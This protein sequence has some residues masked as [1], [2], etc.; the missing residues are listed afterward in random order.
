MADNSSYKLH[1]G[2]ENTSKTINYGNFEVQFPKNYTNNSAFIGQH[3]LTMPESIVNDGGLA[4]SDWNKNN[5]GKLMSCFE[6][7][8][9]N[10]IEGWRSDTD[11]NTSEKAQEADWNDDDYTFPDRINT[12]ADLLRYIFMLRWKLEN[13]QTA[14]AD[15]KLS[16]SPS[17]LTVQYHSTS[18]QFITATATQSNTK[19]KVK[20]YEWSLSN[21]KFSISA[22]KDTEKV[23]IRHN[24][25]D[26]LTSTWTLQTPTTSIQQQ[27]TSTTGIAKVRCNPRTP[28]E[29]A[30][31]PSSATLTCKVKWTDNHEESKSINV[32]S[33]GYTSGTKP[34]VS[35]YQWTITSGSL[36]ADLSND[37]S[38]ECTL[39]GKSAG[40]VKVKCTVT[41]S[42]RSTTE[43]NEV[44]ITV[45][46]PKT[47]YYWYAGQTA[48]TTISGTPTVDDTNFTNNK[49]HTIGTTLTNISKLVTGGI[50]GEEWYVAVPKDKY[51][52]TADDLSTPDTSWTIINTINVGTIEYSVYDTGISL[53]RC[54]TYLKVK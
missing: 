5:A 33:N 37:D 47:I 23:T 22:G 29:N 43:T 6:I 16:I 15:Y 50:K 14:P 26:V 12:S 39:T 7:N 34:S 49:W 21:D 35:G 40:T 45:P 44:I 41:W 9:G 32:K 4:A 30:P 38:E 2:D 53:N 48:P 31:T 24:D 25:K 17:S 20:S 46:A 42:D 52:P 19:A 11:S 18:P 36:Y 28:T 13:I 3:K 8:W 54:A 51:Q 27:M 10:A 1:I